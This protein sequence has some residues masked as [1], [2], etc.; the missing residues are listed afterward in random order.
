MTEAIFAV[1]VIIGSSAPVK[2]LYDHRPQFSVFASEDDCIASAKAVSERIEKT[3][4]T[5]AVAVCL[6]V[7]WREK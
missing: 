7:A 3:Y 5:R 1:F 2:L 4:A 6:P